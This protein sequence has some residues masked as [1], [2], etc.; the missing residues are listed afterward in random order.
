M[1]TTRTNRKPVTMRVAVGGRKK[2]QG[3]KW[4]AKD[5]RL[6]LY[7]RDDLKCAFC[8]CVV[9]P[10]VTATL[11]HVLACELGG[12]N[13]T[14]NLVTA[15]ISCNSAKRDLSMRKWFAVLRMNNVNTNRIG[16]RVRRQTR[17]DI[18]TMRKHAK[19]L[20]KTVGYQS[21]CTIILDAKLAKAAKLAA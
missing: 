4:C 12:T 15:C 13:D 10:G 20:I 21:A 6:A 8:D 16:S 1:S 19:S 17:K 5:K 11:D 2:G 3:S 14:T 18:T 9:V 7:L